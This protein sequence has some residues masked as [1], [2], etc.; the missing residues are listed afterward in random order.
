MEDFN[1][2]LLAQKF[3]KMAEFFREKLGPLKKFQGA[4]T[5]GYTVLKL[6]RQDLFD[7]HWDK[8]PDSMKFLDDGK[9]VS[10][11]GMEL[12][13]AIAATANHI[14]GVT[15]TKLPDSSSLALFAPKL[16]YS[17][18][19]V[20]GGDP[21]RAANSLLKLGNMTPAQKWFLT[22]QIK[23]KA[24][25]FGV[26]TGLLAANQQ[27]NNMFGDKKKLNGVP[28]FMGG[29]GF[30]PM[31]SDFMKFRVAGMNVAWASPFLTLGRLPMRLI[32]IGMGDGGKSK[33]IIYPD[34][35]MY[36]TVGSYART[37]TS[38]ALSPVLSLLMKGDY[39]NRP[40]PQIPG[41]GPPPPVPKRLEAKGI[42]PY[43]WPEFA[44]QTFLPIPAQEAAKEVWHYGLGTTPEQQKALVK[45]FTIITLM[46]GTGGR[47]QEDW[48][49]TT[50]GGPQA[51]KAPRAPS[52]PKAPK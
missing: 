24:T 40:L 2:P 17:R 33:F 9:T 38:P 11:D 32:Q 45:A 19:Q 44:A 23:E 34:E 22:N 28:E 35:S 49:E 39:E 29:K 52:A 46:A 41:Y 20:M 16:L 31:S 27:L 4:G 30:D 26:F 18:L 42:K 6:M 13:K 12:A 10:P 21:F 25:I 8:L 51:P 48:P 14:T 50:K 47:I 5:R 43:T 37:Q 1:D 7:Q 36:K 15:E 3:P